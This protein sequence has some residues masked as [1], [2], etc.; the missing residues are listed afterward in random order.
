MKNK[1]GQVAIEFLFT[2]GWAIMAI[3][4]TLVTLL[5]FNVLTPER[6]VSQYCD[7]GSQI[8]CVEVGLYDNGTIT[9]FIRNNHRVD[10]ELSNIT[11]YSSSFNHFHNLDSLRIDRGEIEAV[12]ID[13]GRSFFAGDIKRLRVEIYYKRA[14]G[15]NYYYFS[16]AVLTGILNS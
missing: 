3:T 10:I 16:G 1:R 7:M 15:S 4:I 2:Y 9:F 5:Y 14:G 13:L 12:N 8:D 11:F 6:F